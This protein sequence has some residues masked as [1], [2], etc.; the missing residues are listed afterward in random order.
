[1]PRGSHRIGE[2]YACAIAPDGS[3]VAVGGC[4]GPSATGFNVYLF[5]RESGNLLPPITGL[6]DVVFDLAFSPDG[7]QLAVVLGAGHGLRL[8]DLQTG[9]LLS[10]DR[11]YYANSNHCVFDPTGSLLIT[12]SDDTALR[13]YE[14]KAG[15]L[16]HL[17]CVPSRGSADYH[18]FPGEVAFSPDGRRFVVGRRQ[19]PWVEVFDAK[20]FQRLFAPNTSDVNHGSLSSVAWLQDGSICAAGAW[21]A[22]GHRLLRCWADGG[23]APPK[24]LPLSSDTVMRLRSLPGGRLAFVSQDPRIGVLGPDLTSLWEVKPA[25][26]D[27]REQRHTLAVTPDGSQIS[28]NYDR[29]GRDQDQAIFSVPDYTLRKGSAD[30]S[31]RT[32][33]YSATELV[34]NE[35]DWQNGHRPKL[36][37]KELDVGRERPTCL[38]IARSMDRFVFGTQQFVRMFHRSGTEQ[39]RRSLPGAPVWSVN[40]SE[41]ERLVIA[42]YGDGTIRWHRLDDGTE[43]L[44]FLPLADRTN[45]VAW[46]PEGIYASTPGARGVLRWHVNHGWDTAAESIPVHEFAEQH[47]PEILP[48]VIREMDEVRALGL[49]EREKIRKAVRSRIGVDP[50]ARLHILTVGV[51]RYKEPRAS[52]LNLQF[53]DKDARDIAAALIDSQGSLY[54]EVHVQRLLNAQGTRRTILNA[55]ESIK[56]AMSLSGSP[57]GR[58]LALVHF[59]GHG[60][61]ENKELYFYPYEVDPGS[62]VDIMNTALSFQQIRD[63]ILGIAESGR[64]LVLLD[65]CFSG[66]ATMDTNV[67]TTTVRAALGAPNVTLLT[68]NIPNKP[69][70]EDERW[71][72]GAL[73]GAFLDAL[74]SHADRDHDGLLSVADLEYHIDRKLIETSSNRQSLG[75][76]KRFDGSIFVAGL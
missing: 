53:A 13:I 1:V 30:A 49:A 15:H 65:M 42:A 57:S 24:D 27:F 8:I 70:F 19:G 26:A 76:E 2:L 23:H 48:I 11:R 21:T 63:G 58:D 31:F 52:H 72:N 32:P 20:T 10:E 74:R 75:I 9:E 50:G 25:K 40:I 7:K 66:A 44:A 28:F 3:V 69:S 56:S 46:T 37:G 5:E 67:L 55:F 36:N 59:S 34:F 6:P 14:L 71:L 51:G 38:A 73:T 43:L 64:A 35:S 39:W 68:S 54:A 62:P 18:S 4:T 16:H 12:T 29:Y 47:R 17:H 33:R 22:E 45:W 61:M 60:S 41:D